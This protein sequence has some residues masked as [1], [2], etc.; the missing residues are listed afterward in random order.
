MY[1][2]I[3]LQWALS[4]NQVVWNGN[5][6]LILVKG[7]RKFGNELVRIR[8]ILLDLRL[9]VYYCDSQTIPK[10]LKVVN[11][12]F[13]WYNEIIQG[14]QDDS[15]LYEEIK[16]ERADKGQ[17]VM[18]IRPFAMKAFV[19]ERRLRQMVENLKENPTIHVTYSR[20]DEEDK[21][22][23]QQLDELQE[24]FK[25]DDQVIVLDPRRVKWKKKNKVN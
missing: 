13:F 17:K 12:L 11:L 8:E 1:L 14:R 16:W 21:Q 3:G 23:E 20:F 19:S 9:K 2:K 24:M 5:T 15:D 6:I 25:D 22:R 4:G 10:K 7:N 18:S